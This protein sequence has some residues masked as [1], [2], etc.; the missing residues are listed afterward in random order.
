[1]SKNEKLLII[2][3]SP[4]KTKTIS[5]YVD[6]ASVI[7]SVGH[8]KDL[9]KKD[10]GIDID[11]DFAMQIESMPDKK[12]FLSQLKKEVKIA[13][14]ISIASPSRSGSVAIKMRSAIFTSFFN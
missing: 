2:V 4:S 6:N 12:K 7:A 11:N 3:E 1:M 9:P 14:R 8:F 10:M 13:D 5:K